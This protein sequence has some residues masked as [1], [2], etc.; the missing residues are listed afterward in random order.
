MMRPDEE[1]KSEEPMR[2]AWIALGTAL[3]TAS[4]GCG[5]FGPGDYR[6]YRVAFEPSEPQDDCFDSGSVPV[7]VQDDTSNLYASGTFVVFIG[8]DENFYLDAGNDILRG[9]ESGDT[10]T[11]TGNSTDVT[12]EGDPMDPTRTTVT[13]DLQIDFT[14]DGKVGQGTVVDTQSTE[15]SGPDCPD[16]A[17]NACTNITNFI[18]GEVEDVEIQHEI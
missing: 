3:V 1:S 8:A 9:T 17:S 6:V 7:D 5:G 14:I 15:C 11:F 13:T 10:I 16:P 4:M 12:V 2:S 18:A